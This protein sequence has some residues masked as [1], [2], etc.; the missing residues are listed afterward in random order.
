M[1]TSCPRQSQT[2]S[3][4]IC[5]VAAPLATDV[6]PGYGPFGGAADAIFC[7]KFLAE[8]LNLIQPFRSHNS[9]LSPPIIN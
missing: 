6:R 4:S 9:K 7:I 1:G 8:P 3:S 5:S 2:V